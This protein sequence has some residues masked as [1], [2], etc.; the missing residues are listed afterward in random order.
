MTAPDVKARLRAIR[1]PRRQAGGHRPAPLAHGGGG[2]RAPLHPPGH[3]CAVPLRPRP[4]A[5]RGEP[6][7]ARPPRTARGRRRGGGARWRASSRPEAVGAAC[8]I[9]ADTIRRHRTR[10]RR[11]PSRPRSTVASARASRSSAPLAS[12][13]VDVLN[14][15]TGNLDR[16]GGAMFTKAAAGASNTRGEPGRGKGVRFGRR[17][18]PRARAARG[19]RR[20]AGRLPRRGDRDAGRGPDPGAHH[21]RRQSGAQ[22]AERRAAVG[23]ARLARVHGE[24]RHL[25]ERDDAPR[26]RDPAVALAA[27]V[28][29]LRPR[30]SGSSPSATTQTT[31]RPSFLRRR[32]GRPTGRPSCG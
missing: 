27:R 9:P 16:P 19:L 13:L 1:A 11:A 26:G 23:R 12:W 14:V 17:D 22:H 30:R 21:H 10:A 28:V 29:A 20:A 25:P 4:H 32:V 8:G 15:L 18:E 24:P 6:R 31:R 2:R 7:P 5:V 3:R